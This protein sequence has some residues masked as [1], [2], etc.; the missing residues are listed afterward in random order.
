MSGI[1]DN[2][3]YWHVIA[4]TLFQGGVLVMGL[5]ALVRLLAPK[6]WIVR[7][8]DLR[9]A[10]GTMVALLAVWS[11]VF[12]VLSMITGIWMT[13]GYETVTSL[14]LTLNK[15]MFG[16]FA[17]MALVLMLVLRFKYG[18]QLWD[19][20]ALRISY[21]LLALVAA[22]VAVVNGSLGGEAGLIGTA[23]SQIWNLLGVNPGNPMI[24]P[25][26]GGIAFLAVVIVATGAVIGAGMLKRR[27][28][29]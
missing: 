29:S 6:E 2:G 26:A 16:T 28:S 21:I 3:V 14:S 27:A 17:L 18:P 7:G 11:L 9:L 20:V 4:S 1:I 5:A 13:W 10:N 22:G 12:A 15:S 19:D 8:V 25:T 24:F 23:L